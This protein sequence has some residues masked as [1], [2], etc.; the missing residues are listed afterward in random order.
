MINLP[1]YPRLEEI[2]ITLL[3]SPSRFLVLTAETAAGKS[4]AVPIA[5]LPHVKGKIIMLEP[6]RIA[7]IAIASRIASLLGEDVGQTAGYRLHLDSRVTGATRIEVITEAILTRRIQGDP[8]LAGVS[9]VILDEFHERSVHSDLALALLKEIVSLRTD[10]FVIVMSA[11]I[12]TER[13]ASYLD[14]PVLHIPG[15]VWPIDIVYQGS[16][17][18]RNPVYLEDRVT[19]AVK[20]ELSVPGGNILIFLPGIAEI[21]RMRERLS[22]S[23]ADILILHSSVPFEEQRRVL[24]EGKAERRRVILS[25]SIAETSITVPGVSVVIDSGFSRVGRFDIPTGMYRLVTET[26]SV[27]SATQRAG[28]S[29]R[30]GPG[31]CIRLWAESDVR[32]SVTPPEITRTDIMPL[33]LECAQW[34]ITEVNG[35][36][37][38]DPPNSG[39]WSRARELLQIMGALDETGRVTPFGNQMT[40][41]GV[42]PRLA[43]VALGGSIDLAVKYSQYSENTRESELFRSDLERRVRGALNGKASARGV[44]GAGNGGKNTAIKLLAGFPDRIARHTGDGIYQFPSGRLASLHKDVRQGRAQH[45]EWIIATDVDAGE[46]EGRIWAYEELND[47]DAE[48]WLSLHGLRSCEITFGAGNDIHSGIKKIERLK[49]GKLVLSERR[50]EPGSGDFAPAFCAFVR[51]SGLS[52][53]PW[54]PAS[55]SFALRARFW[56]RRQRSESGVTPMDE[57]Q[58]LESLE[59]WLVPFIPSKNT[60]TGDS[61][62]DALRYRCD[63]ACIDR[64]VPSRITLPSGASRPLS[65]EELVPGEGPMPVLEIKIQDLF[66]CADTPAVLG[67]P[68]LLRLLSPARRPLQ[69]TR[70]LRGFWKNTWPVIIKEMKGRYP[71]HKWPENPFLPP[72]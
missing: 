2:C 13:V 56:Y 61:F 50:L 1:I 32:L 69:I 63:A 33:V 35:L 23:D 7:T 19:A 4:T 31:K 60:L 29:G 49:Y 8:S 68:V 34:G 53:L 11:T 72:T 42:H 10:L 27:F 16:P 62:L 25:S 71:K 30:T 37:W 28:R 18:S 24:E 17:S 47:A 14:S 36:A 15:R 3:A 46:R 58:L 5:L 38:L 66:G 6:R 48:S 70:D 22:S 52:S 9:V 43:A 45:P 65:Y 40:G 39:A 55:E 20:N 54:T 41:L 57:G 12:D 44:T 21:R 26:E 67:V 51:S 64:E 59:E